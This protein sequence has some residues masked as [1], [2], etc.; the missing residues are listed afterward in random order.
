MMNTMNA[1]TRASGMTLPI[2][3]AQTI[4]G[5]IAVPPRPIPPL[6]MPV[7]TQ[8]AKPQMAA[9]RR[10]K[11][12]QAPEQA[13]HRQGGIYRGG[14]KWASNGAR[15]FSRWV[16]RT[17]RVHSPGHRLDQYREPKGSRPSKC[18]QPPLHEVAQPIQV[19]RS[20]REHKPLRE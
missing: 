18:A 1:A 17:T 9:N 7:N 19:P 2:P 3:S 15:T 4:A 12:G 13:R 16:F 10:G 11:K 8:M 6:M 14:E 5:M 20:I